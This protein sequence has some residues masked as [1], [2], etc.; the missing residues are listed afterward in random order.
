MLTH[1]TPTAA[2]GDATAALLLLLAVVSQAA[3]YAAPAGV[4]PAIR[5]P[6]A[7]SILPGGRM[8]IPIGIQYVTGPGPFAFDD[9]GRLWN[10]R[11]GA[12]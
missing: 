6:G 4:R 11:G 8:I 10:Q 7:A 2:I 3:E 5:R 12:R 9:A 1:T